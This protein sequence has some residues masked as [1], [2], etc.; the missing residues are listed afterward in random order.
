MITSKKFSDNKNQI[1]VNNENYLN[2]L[3]YFKRSL[4]LELLFCNSVQ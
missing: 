2:D 3:T 1:K 4:G